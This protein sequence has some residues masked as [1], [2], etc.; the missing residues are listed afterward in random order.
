MSKYL[1]LFVFTAPIVAMAIREF[2]LRERTFILYEAAPNS[3]LIAAT[4]LWILTQ[5][6]AYF[7]MREAADIFR[8]K[9]RTKSARETKRDL[10]FILLTSGAMALVT[11]VSVRLNR[12]LVS[13]DLGGILVIPLFLAYLA[14]YAAI[15]EMAGHLT[16]T[17]SGL[18][19]HAL[20]F[21]LAALILLFV[22]SALVYSSWLVS[23]ETL[24]VYAGS[25]ALLFLMLFF[26]VEIDVT[27][28]HVHHWLAAVPFILM[29]VFD[30]YTSLVTQCALWAVHL[31][32]ICLFGTQD[33]FVENDRV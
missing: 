15:F 9:S 13:A 19:N 10:A 27:E 7:V 29:C 20:F 8:L 23:P 26:L 25:F 4:A 16:I 28:I 14:L 5:F 11:G 3:V 30:N 21:L 24:G 6:V 22:L 18:A 12:A 17:P 31:H 33:I 2:I 32:G 1:A